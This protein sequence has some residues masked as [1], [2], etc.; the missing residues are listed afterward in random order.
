LNIKEATKIFARHLKNFGGVRQEN[1]LLKELG[2][3][4]YQAQVYFLLTLSGDFIRN[5]ESQDYHSLWALD[6]ESLETAKKFLQTAQSLLEEK[7]TLMSS[8]ELARATGIKKPI[9][10]SYLGISYRIQKIPKVCMD[11]ANGLK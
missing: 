5:G 7:K 3:T 6:K 10:E 4:A 11:Y 9:V 1:I 8:S 2:G